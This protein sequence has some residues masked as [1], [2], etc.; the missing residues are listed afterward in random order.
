MHVKCSGPL[1]VLVVQ[2]AQPVSMKLCLTALTK[3]GSKQD[4]HRPQGREQSRETVTPLGY[5]V[6]AEIQTEVPCIPPFNPRNEC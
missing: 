5:V 4:K 2:K 6:T 1:I 3:G